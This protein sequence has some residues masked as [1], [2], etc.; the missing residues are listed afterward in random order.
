M[1]TSAPNETMKC[2]FASHKAFLLAA[3]N[4]TFDVRQ[5]VIA[6][7]SVCN[8]FYGSG[9]PDITGIGVRPEC[10]LQHEV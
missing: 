3:K 7:S 4:H 9:N 5:N 1:T 10:N 2:D 6:C 8:L